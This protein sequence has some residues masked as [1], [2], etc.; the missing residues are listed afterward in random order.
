MINIK[1]KA[2]TAEKQIQTKQVG[3]SKIEGIL[4]SKIELKYQNNQPYY[5]GFFALEGISNRDIPV[6]FKAD[7]C[8]DNLDKDKP[9]IPP[10]SKVL[11]EGKWAE[12][13]G[14]LR[15]SFTC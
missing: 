12:S 5:L 13:N 10:N 14:C 9:D 3:L 1:E 6:I 2:R 8:S 11:L 15:P 7:N 4:T